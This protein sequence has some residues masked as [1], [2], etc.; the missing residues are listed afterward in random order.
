M[1]KLIII[2]IIGICFLSMI[3]LSIKKQNYDYKASNLKENIME[4]VT[5]PVYAASACITNCHLGLNV[6]ALCVA[7]I[8]VTFPIS[9]VPSHPNRFDYYGTC[10]VSTGCLNNDGATI[11]ATLGTGCCGPFE[12]GA[13]SIDCSDGSFDVISLLIPSG[14]KS[15]SFKVVRTCPPCHLSLCIT[16]VSSCD[17]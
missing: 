10:L 9:C 8:S 12:I 15:A 14:A 11:T 6:D 1:K 3:F 4:L 2:S 5:E 13:M 16:N 7:N 17:N